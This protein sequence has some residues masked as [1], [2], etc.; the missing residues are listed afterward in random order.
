ML[1]PGNMLI[2]DFNGEE[3]VGMFCETNCK[4]QMKKKLK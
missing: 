1:C 4:K 3:I 2:S